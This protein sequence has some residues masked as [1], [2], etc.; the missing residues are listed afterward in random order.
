MQKKSV[1]VLAS[2]GLDSSA[3]IFS[4][5]RRGF[6][7]YPLYIR[8]G[9]RWEKAEQYWLK[10]FLSK[11]KTPDL[12][13]LSTIEYPVKNLLGQ[14]H[15]SFSGRSIPQSSDPDFSVYL[16]GRNIILLGQAGLFCAIRQIP[17]IALAILRGNPFPDATPQFLKAMEKAL[18]SG[19]DF[20]IKITV[21]YAKFSK[22][23]VLSLSEGA[24][25]H[26]AFSCLN[27]RGIRP[28]Q[29]CNKCGE[30]IKALR[31]TKILRN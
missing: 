23:E 1:C 19:L 3:L 24:P 30:R 15:W 29:R 9:F 2:G 20:K 21:P 18:N 31:L 10:R 14:G 17:Q 8:C 7:V 11:I 5:L 16:P 4:L 13:K 27:P 12:Q 6:K 22:K 26:L 25:F 28:C